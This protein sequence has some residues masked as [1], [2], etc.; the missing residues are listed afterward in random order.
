M[1]IIVFVLQHLLSKPSLVISLL[2][3]NIRTAGS[4][5]L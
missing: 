2:N 4:L 5:V 3:A 1:N